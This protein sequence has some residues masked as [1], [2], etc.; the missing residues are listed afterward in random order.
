MSELTSSSISAP[1]KTVPDRLK[2][3]LNME[4]NEVGS[5]AFGVGLSFGLPASA[6][7]FEI[8]S[9]SRPSKISSSS[10][11]PDGISSSFSS[12]RSSAGSHS[13]IASQS[14]SHRTFPLKSHPQSS[15]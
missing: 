3:G 13:K 1:S 15:I 9:S 8:V 6:T 5:S 14:C 11:T 4:V 7:N 10:S 12:S 2:L